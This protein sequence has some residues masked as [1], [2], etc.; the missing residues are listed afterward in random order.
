MNE[1]EIFFYAVNFLVCTV[2]FF[3]YAV[4]FF[5]RP[6][7][8]LICTV[9]FLVCTENRISTVFLTKNLKI[10]EKLDVLK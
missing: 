2:N 9:N 4:N 6:V 5:F 7:N 3:F 10:S 1:Q 8:F